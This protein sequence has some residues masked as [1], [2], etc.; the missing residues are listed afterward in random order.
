M[1]YKRLFETY[2]YLTYK[3]T[4]N[5]LNNYKTNIDLG[6]REGG[7]SD[8]CEQN[9]IYSKSVDLNPANDTV[10]RA[11]L[12]DVNLSKLFKKSVGFITLNAS[13]EH[14]INPVKLL[15]QCNNLLDKKGLIFIRTP[16]WKI[17]W[18]NFYNDVSHV[19]P[20]TPF[21]M[22]HV[23]EQAGFKV[24]LV[25][26]GYIKMPYWLYRIPFRYNIAKYIQTKS[27]VAIA[28]KL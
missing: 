13:I 15:L 22:N 12:N 2:D 8:V 24:L 10:I 14:L 5:R 9:N 26:P 19:T 4:G 6:A 7:F 1:K 21:T 18:K 3:L 23:L 20:F 17:D 16:N 27:I 25:A 28:M 11:D